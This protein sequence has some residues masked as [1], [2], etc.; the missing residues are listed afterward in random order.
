MQHVQQCG[1]PRVACGMLMPD[2]RSIPDDPHRDR[3]PRVSAVAVAQMI[4]V[5]TLLLVLDRF[6]RLAQMVR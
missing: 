2:F 6:V 3:D 4:V 5:V 1:L